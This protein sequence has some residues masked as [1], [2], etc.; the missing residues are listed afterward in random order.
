MSEV[1]INPFSD[2]NG[3]GNHK[4]SAIKILKQTIEILDDFNINYFL[5][6]GTLL[7]YARYNDFIPWDDDIDLVVDQSILDKLDLIKD[8]YNVNLFYKSK[9]DSIKVCFSDGNEIP[10]NDSVKIWKEH[11]IGDNNKYCWPFV[12]LFMYELGHGIHSCGEYLDV[13][14]NDKEVNILRPFSG[15]CLNSFRFFNESDISFFH[16]E[17]DKDEFFPPQ[18]VDF[19]GLKVNIPKNPDYFLSINYGPDYISE[20]R[21][22]GRSHKT[23]TKIQ[24]IIVKV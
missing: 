16:N 14:I 23:E 5:I 11:S 6:S 10:E 19:L 13:I 17:W 20:L 21:S 1:L 9:Y 12:D 18:K 2:E 22:S 8:K 7:G 24:N 15:P 4:E 3:F